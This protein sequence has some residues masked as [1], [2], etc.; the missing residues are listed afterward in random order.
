MKDDRIIDPVGDVV[1]IVGEDGIRRISPWEGEV[2]EPWTVEE[3]DRRIE[4]ARRSLTADTNPVTYLSSEEI[5][6]LQR[7]LTL[8]SWRQKLLDGEANAE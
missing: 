7:V 5:R 6:D 8:E 1:I 3:L 2:F 4:E